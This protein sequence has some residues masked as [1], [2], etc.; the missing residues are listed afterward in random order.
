MVCLSL[1]L[2]LGLSACKRTTGVYLF[3][4]LVLGL[5]TQLTGSK[6]NSYRRA[7]FSRGFQPSLGPERAFAVQG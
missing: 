1:S 2:S 6:P 4:G 5:Q 7:S 3:S